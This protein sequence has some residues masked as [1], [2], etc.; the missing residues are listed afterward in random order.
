MS[1]RGVMSRVIVSKVSL[2]RLLW[3]SVLS[4]AYI[5]DRSLEAGKIALSFLKIP[6]LIRILE[7]LVLARHDEKSKMNI[8]IRVSAPK[9]TLVS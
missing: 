6:P 4:L 1:S 8:M 2:F 5:F 7:L 9:M 3:L